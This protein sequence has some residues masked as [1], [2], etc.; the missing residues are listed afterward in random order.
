LWLSNGWIDSTTAQYAATHYGAYSYV[1]PEGLKIVSLNTDFWYASNVFNYYN[2][3]NPDPSG[4]L[5]FLISELEASEAA[6]QRVRS[7]MSMA[8]T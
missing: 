5:A 7:Q 6:N 1:T 8:L 3:T 2:F 4:M